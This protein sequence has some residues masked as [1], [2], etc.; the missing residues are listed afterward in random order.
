M[1]SQGL[2]IDDEFLSLEGAANEFGIEWS[3]SPEVTRSEVITPDGAVSAVRWGGAPVEAV[4]LHGRAP[5][6]SA[7]SWDSIALDWGVPVLAVDTPGHGFSAQ[8]ADRRYTPRLIAPAVGNAIAALAP[9]PPLIVGVSFG[10]LTTIALAAL[11]PELVK[12]IAL[13]DILPRFEAPPAGSPAPEAK[14]DPGPPAEPERFGSRQEIID[15]LSSGATLSREAIAR[16]VTANTVQLDDGSWVWRFDAG[17]KVAPGELD[18]PGLWDDLLALQAPIL[19]VRGG[20]SP[21]VADEVVA[22]LQERRP[23][24]TV[25][26]VDDAGHEIHDERPRKLARILADFHSKLE[27]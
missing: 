12:A 22:E 13:V 4:L 10:G 26:T 24:V 3:G 5:G 25:V 6:Q 9:A 17:V 27:L 21:V 14:A 18:F 2:K 8:R 20:K 1:M 15:A 23:D 19:L 11:R 7:R 16:S